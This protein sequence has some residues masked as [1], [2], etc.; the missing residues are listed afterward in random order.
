MKTE[1]LA[2]LSALM[3]STLMSSTLMSS[4]CREVAV[5]K[6]LYIT[7]TEIGTD[8][9]KPIVKISPGTWLQSYRAPP[10]QLRP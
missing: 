3:S 1:Y 10:V 5:G 9:S 8:D 6:L 4:A 7:V 2:S